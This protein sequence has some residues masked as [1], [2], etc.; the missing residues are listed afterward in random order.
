[1]STH[2]FNYL[3][4]FLFEHVGNLNAKDSYL[5][6]TYTPNICC[7]DSKIQIAENSSTHNNIALC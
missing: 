6:C 5:E 2:L 4:D 3:I 7:T 1:M